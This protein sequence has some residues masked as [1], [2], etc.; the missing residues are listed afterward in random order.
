MN[1]DSIMKLLYVFFSQHLW[2]VKIAVCIIFIL[3]FNFSINFIYNRFMPKLAK[4]N[5]VWDDSLLISIYKPVKIL[6]W[7]LGLIYAFKIIIPYKSFFSEQSIGAAQALS[8]LFITIWCLMRFTKQIEA[9]LIEKSSL[10]K[11]IDKTT[12]SAISK[13]ICMIIIILGALTFLQLLGISISVVLAFGGGGAIVIGLAAKDLLANFFGGLMVYL[14]RSFSVGDWI[15]SPDK[16]IEGTVEHIGWRSTRIR[17]FK[18]RLLYIPNSLFLTLAIENPSRMTNRR[19]KTVF[20]VRY[21]DA[22]K[23]AKIVT[24]IEN[25]LK[26]HP[27][28]DTRQTLFVKLIEFGASSLDILIYT[29]TKTT[30]WVKFQSIQEEIFLEIIDIVYNKHGASM[31]FPTRT[32]EME[33]SITVNLQNLK[34]GNR[35][36]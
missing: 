8:V 18:K 12:V 28:I 3:L 6:V 33:D 4:T 24:D 22:P 7:L 32:L 26:N 17:T 16:E 15:A 5:K 34:R 14:D 27:E 11:T 9:R 23:I 13:L 30:Q 1:L 20:G 29:F 31:A 10:I 2:L 19:I 21:C 25:M 35:N 36:D